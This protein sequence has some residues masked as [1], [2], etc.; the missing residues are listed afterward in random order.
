MAASA[1]LQTLLKKKAVNK[2]LTINTF[3]RFE[4]FIICFYCSNTSSRYL[5]WALLGSDLFDPFSR[6]DFVLLS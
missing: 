6:S 2:R 4:M 1:F 3:D 5:R